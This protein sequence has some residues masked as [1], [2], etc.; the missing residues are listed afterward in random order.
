MVDRKVRYFDRPGSRN[1][2]ET[3][4]IV[5]EYAAE[6]GVK[7]VVIAAERGDSALA[8]AKA[9]EGTDIEV[10]AVTLQAGRWTKFSPPDWDMMEEIKSLGGKVVTATHVL[11]GNVESAIRER[12]G[13]LAPTEIIGHTLYLLG[14]GMKVAVEITVMAA[15]A[16][17]VSPDEDV[18]AVAGTGRGVDTAVLIRPAYS[19]SFFDLR[20]R[21]ILAMPRH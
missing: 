2:S 21:E 8:L 17:L 7:K 12:F 19:T 5:K 3:L 9:V 18:I 14:Q 10:I 6:T 20:V 4:R 13:G 16:G 15:D 1:T 11:I